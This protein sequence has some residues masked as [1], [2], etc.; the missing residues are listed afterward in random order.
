MFASVGAAV[1]KLNPTGVAL[2]QVLAPGAY[3]FMPTDIHPGKD[4]E[5][6]SLDTVLGGHVDVRAYPPLDP[7]KAHVAVI[8]FHGNGC[9]ADSMDPMWQTLRHQGSVFAVNLPGYGATSVPADGSELEL[10]MAAG[11]QAVRDHL[12]HELGFAAAHIVWYGLSLGGSQ[13][14]IG[15]EMTPGSHIAVQNT[16]TSVTDVTGN[17]LQKTIGRASG[18]LAAVASSS[19]MPRGLK[20][21]DLQYTTDGLDTVSKFK[22]IR[23]S[24]SHAGS[25]LLVLGAEADALM[26]NAYPATIAHAFYGEDVPKDCLR[27]APGATHNSPLDLDSMQLLRTFLEHAGQ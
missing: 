25:R 27:V 19:G 20:R 13:A 4:A 8:G 10:H 15:L 9:T 11:V 6:R 1:G 5:V 22:K 16:F 17:V 23:E 21:R 2:R 14:A 18:L 24:G 3:G 7:S 12:L 26:P